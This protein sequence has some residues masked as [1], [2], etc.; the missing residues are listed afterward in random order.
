MY[1]AEAFGSF[2]TST[3]ATI[4]IFYTLTPHLIMNHTLA[5]PSYI[6]V[7]I[8]ALLWHLHRAW[9]SEFFFGRCRPMEQDICDEVKDYTQIEHFFSITW[10]VQPICF[11]LATLLRMLPKVRAMQDQQTYLLWLHVTLFYRVM[12]FNLVIRM[13]CRL[14]RTAGSPST[15]DPD[16]QYQL[17]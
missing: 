8:P 17:L 10:V 9:A 15:E 1:Q 4:W 16:C 3:N 11:L 14:V 13:F 7:Q 12:T 2:R 6:L 5:A